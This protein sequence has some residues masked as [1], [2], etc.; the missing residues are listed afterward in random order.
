MPKMLG[1]MCM[2]PYEKSKLVTKQYLI[3]CHFHYI[4]KTKHTK[5][6]ILL[7]LLIGRGKKP[8]LTTEKQK[9][10]MNKLKNPQTNR[11]IWK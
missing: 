11:S 6:E 5:I 1:G 8:S 3:L 10:Q 9:K 4:I 7:W 2:N